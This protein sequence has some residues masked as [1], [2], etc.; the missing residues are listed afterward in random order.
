[1]YRL[2]HSGRWLRARGIVIVLVAILVAA[3]S[4]ASGPASNLPSSAPAT[5]AAIPS[6]TASVAASPSESVAAF[7]LSLTDDDGTAVTIPAEP[8]KIVSLTPAATETLF[9]LGLGDRVL[10]KVDDPADFP[11][12]A[13]SVP[14]V[15]PFDKIDVEKIVGLGSDLVI[16]GGSGGTP[17]DAIQ[18]LR[19]LGIPVLV[20]YAADVD[21]VRHDLE[22]TGAAAGRG[23]A[24]KDLSA[25]MQAGFDQVAAATRDLHR[26]RVFYETGD[27][28]AIYGIADDSFPASMIRLAG[29]EPITTGSATNWEQSSEK[30]IAADPELILLGDAAYGVT[31]AKVAARPGWKVMTAVRQKAIVGVDD[32]VITRPGPRLVQG[33]QA[34]ARA[35][36]P[37]AALPSASSP[38]A[39][40]AAPSA[41]ASGVSGY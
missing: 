15:G 4:A 36:H 34:L 25:S 33:L 11:P 39:S 40:G 24:A 16:A 18:R 29:G 1:M 6:P 27:Q 28:P 30:L 37:D 38:A 14:L 8:R 7:P 19:S 5:S 21:G 2:R 32:I 41:T 20:I 9:A 13:H 35:I 26:P 22:L 23:G 17:P 10:G 12:E 3:C 31:A